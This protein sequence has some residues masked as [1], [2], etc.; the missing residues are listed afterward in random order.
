MF[1]KVHS[2][3]VILN[4]LK[5]TEGKNILV[6]G[7]RGQG[8]R[9]VVKRF[10]KDRYQYETPDVITMGQEQVEKAQAVFI[11]DVGQ[12]MIFN[13]AMD[14]IKKMLKN[15]QQMVFITATYNDYEYLLPI[16]KKYHVQVLR[17]EDLTDDDIKKI[18]VA[19]M[20]N[21]DISKYWLSANW[22]EMVDSLSHKRRDLGSLTQG[23]GMID[24][25]AGYHRIQ[26]EKSFR[27]VI[28]TIQDR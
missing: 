14:T 12:F 16:V 2:Q 5:H 27:E 18:W 10:L 8:K 11:E 6:L 21:L 13:E 20:D 9:T 25:I 19:R 24:L 22:V 26:P 17:L 28:G 23:L 1:V 3:Q 15:P 7:N 4:E